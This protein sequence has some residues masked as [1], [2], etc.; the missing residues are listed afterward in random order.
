MKIPYLDD[1]IQLINDNED[2][3]AYNYKGKDN[4]LLMSKELVDAI[5]AFIE[6]NKPDNIDEKELLKVV[7]RQAFELSKNDVVVSRSGQIFIK[8]FDEKTK[9]DVKEKDVGT[10]AGRY[11]GFS[12]EELHD[13]YQEFFADEENKDFFQFI[14]K[15][16]FQK[17]FV[18]HPINNEIYEKYVFSYI[19]QIIAEQLDA[20]Y[21]DDNDGFFQGFSGYIFRIH[22]KEVFEHIADLML[23]EISINNNYI[24]KFLK[25]YS[26]NILVVGGKKYK[27]PSLETEDGLRWNVVS[28]LSI[29]KVYTK[30][31]KNLDKFKKEMNKIKKEMSQFYVEGLS[32]L[33][34]NAL[35]Y[36]KITNLEKDI[37]DQKLELEKNYDSLELSTDENEDKKIKRD[38][39]R[40][41]SHTGTMVNQKR[42]IFNSMISKAR[43]HQYA[44]LQK[45]LE[46]LQKEYKKEKKVILQNQKAYMSMRN[47]LVKALTEKRQLL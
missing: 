38:I 14:A 35:A 16:F 27:I 18:E 22:F 19:K 7:I 12:E 10:V 33:E 31:K 1:V 32:P 47:S 17:Y 29:A 9:Q 3:I 2:L 37:E 11:N 5:Y 20:M 42:E 13:F 4:Q 24:I 28:M 39:I 45:E 41:K 6:K 44:N 8:I 30:S 26:L 25:Y 21:D 43:F 15:E 23:Y 46:S 40:I 34:Y 36:D